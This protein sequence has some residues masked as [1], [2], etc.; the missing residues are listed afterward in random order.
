MNRLIRLVP[1]TSNYK[2]EA[3]RGL[4]RKPRSALANINNKSV[5]P[6]AVDEDPWMEVKDDQTGGIYYWNTFY[7]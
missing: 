7:F 3:V 4:A 2:L 5:P 6:A 1:K